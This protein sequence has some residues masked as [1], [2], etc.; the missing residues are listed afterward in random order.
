M[1]SS[2]YIEFLLSGIVWLPL[3]ILLIYLYNEQRSASRYPQDVIILLLA[4][5]FMMRCIW[6]FAVAEQ[7]YTLGFILIGRVAFLLLF[8]AMSMLIVMW[9]RVGI[10][11]ETSAT[12]N[13]NKAPEMFSAYEINV[14]FQHRWILPIYPYLSS[15]Y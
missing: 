13:D 3:T 2:L 4:A 15:L 10:Q 11:R 8:S 7:A 5:G 14:G 1:S 12:M 6:F 9:T